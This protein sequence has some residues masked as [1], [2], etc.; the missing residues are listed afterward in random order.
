[1]FFVGARQ[2]HVIR[3]LE[4]DIAATHH[5]YRVRVADGRDFVLHLDVRTGEWTLGRIIEAGRVR[6]TRL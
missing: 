3:V 5:S 1:M 4:R 6:A 2:L